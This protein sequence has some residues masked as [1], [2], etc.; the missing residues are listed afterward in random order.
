MIHFI[1]ISVRKRKMMFLIPVLVLGI[2]VPLLLRHYTV[3]Y[4]G[5]EEQIMWYALVLLHTCLPMLVS[6]WIVLLYQDFF[7]WDGNELLYY[8]YPCSML[9]K[10]YAAAVIV[11]VILESAV[12][13]GYRLIVP[14]PDFVLAQLVS[15]TLCVA[16]FTCLCAFLMQNTGASMLVSIG[17]CVYLNMIDRSGYFNFISVFPYPDAYMVWDA[18]RVENVLA[19][20]AVCTAAVFVC[21]RYR[22]KYH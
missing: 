17:Y 1:I 19:A 22:R 4:A 3:M 11:Y 6:W 16:S 12:F 13:C 18:G 7:G 2:F 15:E 9:V 8:Y 10:Q 5:Y 21:M 20:A 14:A